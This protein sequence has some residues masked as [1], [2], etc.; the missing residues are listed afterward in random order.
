MS[1]PQPP[2]INLAG[3]N[4]KNWALALLLGAVI[5]VC[6]MVGV[7]FAMA[8][9]NPDSEVILS[10]SIDLTLL[11]GILIGIATAAILFV[12]Q[13]LNNKQTQEAVANTDKVW[14][15][16]EALSVLPP[17]TPGKRT[18]FQMPELFEA[19]MFW[20][21]YVRKINEADAELSPAEQAEAIKILP[22]LTAAEME[23][24]IPI[25]GPELAES[26]RKLIS[27]HRATNRTDKDKHG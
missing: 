11:M 22:G 12:G 4:S 27:K 9:Q 14:L 17:T 13:Q 19:M 18:G 8:I 23:A 10:G 3:Q 25:T 21:M 20:G 6:A 5:F 1:T 7:A 16:S 15:E 2:V 26:I 24:L